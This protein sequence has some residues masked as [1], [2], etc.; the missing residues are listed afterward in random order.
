[1]AQGPRGKPNTIERE[2]GREGGRKGG[3]EGKSNKMTPNDLL[4]SLINALL[5]HPQRS[6]LLHQM[7]KNTQPE[8]MQRPRDLGTVSSKWEIC[9][10]FI[11]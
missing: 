6:F 10:K 1:M 5:S 2:W 3:R 4:Y 11:P 9:I 8:N 7:G